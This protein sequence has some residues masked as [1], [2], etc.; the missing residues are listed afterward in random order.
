MSKTSLVR[1][2]DEA[3]RCGASGTLQT[4]CAALAVEMQLL[5]RMGVYLLR[6]ALRGADGV[7]GNWG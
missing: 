1:I 6:G 7:C 5:T 4:R 3:E 2:S